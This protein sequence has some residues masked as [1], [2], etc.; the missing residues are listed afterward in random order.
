MK[1]TVFV[2]FDENQFLQF[3][4][5]R[6]E[7][8]DFFSQWGFLLY[9]V[10]DNNMSACCLVVTFSVLQLIWPARLGVSKYSEHKMSCEL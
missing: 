4:G 3:R 5:I 2:F 1:F 8:L 7:K 9:L 6:E 10:Q